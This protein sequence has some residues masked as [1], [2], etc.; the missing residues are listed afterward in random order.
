MMYEVMGVLFLVMHMAM[1]TYAR[2][3]ST[4]LTRR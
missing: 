2:D 3:G 4:L 1:I